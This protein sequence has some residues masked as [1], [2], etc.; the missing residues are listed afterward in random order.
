MGKALGWLGGILATVIAGW[1]VWYLTLQPVPA[2]F[3]GMV[4][5]QASNAPVSKATVI[6]D[7]R[8][9]SNSG[10]YR[11]ITDENGSYKLEL[12]NLGKSAN[13]SVFAEAGGFAKSAPYSFP[14]A[15]DNRR[16]FPLT[17]T[18]PPVA[19][20]TPQYPHAVAHLRYIPKL[21]ANRIKIK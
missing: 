16:D 6:F 9:V 14:G 19:A 5:D 8:G 7:V 2:T 4:Y 18:H 21:A 15:G 1:L 11:D 13:V 17:S 10:P 20:G 3:E 12:S